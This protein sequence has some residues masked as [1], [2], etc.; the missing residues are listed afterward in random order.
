MVPN[1]LITGAIIAGAALLILRPRD[2]G[3]GY[4]SGLDSVPDL[5][6]RA[7]FRTVAQTLRIPVGLLVEIAR[8]ESR[9]NP[10]TPDGRDGEIGLM[11]I[12]PTTVALFGGTADDLRYSSSAIYYAGMYLRWIADRIGEDWYSVAVGYN[13]GPG[14]VIPGTP[15]YAKGP[16]TAARL[17]GARVYT[18]PSADPNYFIQ[19]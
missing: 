8:I 5:I 13:G 10:N 14:Y 11:Q 2:N 9:F 17:Y 3:K 7:Q 6:M 4:Y 19:G 18:Y 15:Y 1:K 16:S 12:K